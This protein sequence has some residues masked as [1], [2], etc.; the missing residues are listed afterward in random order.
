MTSYRSAS[1]DLLEN[2]F[3]TLFFQDLSLS[4]SGSSEDQLLLKNRELSL[5]WKT[6]ELGTLK[7]GLSPT[8]PDQ[9]MPG[10]SRE[11]QIIRQGCGGEAGLGWSSRS[12]HGSG[13]RAGRVAKQGHSNRDT[14]VT[15]LKPHYN[16]A[17]GEAGQHW[18]GLREHTNPWHCL[19]QNYKILQQA[20]QSSVRTWSPAQDLLWWRDY[21]RLSGKVF[22]QQRW[23]GKSCTLGR[24]LRANC[25]HKY[26]SNNIFPT[27]HQLCCCQTFWFWRTL[28]FLWQMLSSMLY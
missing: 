25:I 11:V 26:I 10:D 18:Q 6:E 5:V 8:A 17:L 15:E 7:A 16:R 13:S 24:S 20:P 4:L 12:V 1:C 9:G 14:A 19:Q 22:F 27:L 28:R 2:S 3:V 21:S 23:S